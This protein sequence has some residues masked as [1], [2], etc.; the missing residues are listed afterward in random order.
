MRVGT[1]PKWA[2]ARTWPS[3]KADLVLA[4]VEPDEVAARVHQPHQE[5]PGPT[6]LTPD[7]DGDLGALAPP[8]AQV[9]PHQ[10]HT[11][12]SASTG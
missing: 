9:A 11:S 10:R 4:V 8:T 6:P 7:L 1:P 5:L 3:R 2:N 12:P